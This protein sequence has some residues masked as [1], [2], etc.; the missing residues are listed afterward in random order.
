M[1]PHTQ[2][3]TIQYKQI[4][5]PTGKP[6]INLTHF[7]AKLTLL[8]WPGTKPTIYPRYVYSHV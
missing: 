4:F 6:K 2:W 1:L 5:I 3:T 8:Q 7:I